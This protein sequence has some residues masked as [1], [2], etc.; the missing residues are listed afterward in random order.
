LGGK[1]AIWCI[2]IYT[3]ILL[4]ISPWQSMQVVM[5]SLKYFMGMMSFSLSHEQDKDDIWGEGHGRLA[6]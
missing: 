5:Y 1:K 3:I 6:A 4:A 2:K